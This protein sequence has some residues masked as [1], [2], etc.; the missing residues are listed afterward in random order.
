MQI[1]C[2]CNLTW[3]KPSS[4]MVSFHLNTACFKPI[5]PRQIRR[6]TPTLTPGCC[7]MVVLLPSTIPISPV[8]S[9]CTVHQEGLLLFLLCSGSFVVA[10]KPLFSWRSRFLYTRLFHP[11]TLTYTPLLDTHISP[12]CLL[13]SLLSRCSSKQLSSCPIASRFLS[14]SLNSLS[15][16]MV[17]KV[18]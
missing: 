9:V 2:T 4:G 17:S 3:G 7:I 10:R 16:M 18:K 11:Q 13:H 5:G 12:A 1:P 14:H 15:T 6:H 8:L